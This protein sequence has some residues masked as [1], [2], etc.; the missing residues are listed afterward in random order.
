MAII[1]LGKPLEDIPSGFEPIPDGQYPAR[2]V[3]CAI[4]KT[5]KGDDMLVFT[6]E[7]TE[8]DFAGRK[9]WDRAVLTENALWKVK[10][11]AELIGLESGDEI[12]TQDFIGIECLVE[13]ATEEYNGEPRNQ[14]KNVTAL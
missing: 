1:K 5:K 9:L 8:G 10:Q 2:I 6:F 11:Y 14:I 3:D 13:V 4:D 7:V 12:D